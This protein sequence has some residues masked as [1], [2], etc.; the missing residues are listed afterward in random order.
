MHWQLC[1][2]RVTEV[3]LILRYRYVTG[4][5]CYLICEENLEKE[6]SKRTSIQCII[7]WF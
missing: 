2:L 6:A 3:C 5:L 7:Y 4:S 1:L